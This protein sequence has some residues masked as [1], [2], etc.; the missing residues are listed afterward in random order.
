M[1]NVALVIGV[2][3]LIA[4]AFMYFIDKI[5]VEP[6]NLRPG[7]RFRVMGRTFYVDSVEIQL[8]ESYSGVRIYGIDQ[9]PEEVGDPTAPM[10]YWELGPYTVIG[11]QI[12][13]DI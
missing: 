10:N 11:D 5:T 13:R 4:V 7:A 12:L 2:I 9:T 3:T 1:D 8:N 6:V